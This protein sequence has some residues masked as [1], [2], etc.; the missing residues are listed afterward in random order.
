MTPP[1]VTYADDVLDEV[2]GVDLGDPALY[3]TERPER[4][5]RTMRAAGVPLHMS[6][7]REHWAVTRYQQVRE[8]LG[9]AHLL[10]SE[11]GHR[12]GEKATDAQ[13]G[14][15]AGGKSMLVADDPGH[16]EMR[17]ALESAFTPRQVRRLTAGTEALAR[18]LVAE[19]V[20]RPSVDFVSTV[21]A[22]L[23]T[24]V[25]CDLLGVPASDRPRIVDLTGTAFGGSGHVTGTAQV[26]AHVELLEYCA[27]LIA[28]KR[29]NPADDLATLLA[30]AQMYGGPM[31]LDV[32]IMN[33]HDFLLGGNAS[34]RVALTSVPL[35]MVRQRPFWT[36]LRAGT[37]DFDLATEEFLRF[38]TPVNHIMRTL[39][40]DLE[41]AGVRMRAG[42]LV[43]LWLR[44]ANRDEE[45]F[46]DP[47]TMRVAV[48]RHAQLSFGHG[49]HYCI[50]AYLARLEIRSLF[51][52]LT[53]LV[54]D[55]ELAGAPQ[56]IES[57]LL[58]GYRTV[59]VALRAR[60]N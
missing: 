39:T 49:A 35:T 26:A 19:A 51:R 42:E 21:V 27:M 14:P 13:A 25:A 24:T 44:S 45:V 28:S 58:R 2:L 47:D 41:V 34:A 20:T 57:P 32:A 11:K 8:V 56:R 50:A 37:T 36:A 52:A 4:I 40:G 18:R 53:E 6:G 16:G 9:Q 29:R 48:R 17:R 55:V 15:A 22:P 10:S 12:L 38:E 5:W 23:L 46:D 1:D 54:D 60:R 30:Q 59:P 31:P 33:C 7:L 3:G 43:T